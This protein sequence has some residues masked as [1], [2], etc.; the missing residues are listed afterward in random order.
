MAPSR[1]R[2]RA[3]V[4][5]GFIATGVASVATELFLEWFLHGSIFRYS[6][7]LIPIG[8]ILLGT[9]G[10]SGGIRLARVLH[11]RLG[12]FD[13]IA[14]LGIAAGTVAGIYLMA[15]FSATTARGVHLSSLM[16][17]RDFLPLAL[18][19]TH[20]ST[21][22]Q[23]TGAAGLWGYPLFAL[24]VIG[25]FAAYVG[26]Y[27]FLR[28]IPNCEQCKRYLDVI[29]K[30]QI[31][32]VPIAAA[33]DLLLLAR[34]AQWTNYAVVINSWRGVELPRKA[35]RARILIKLRQCAGCLREHL[36]EQVQIGDGEKWQMASKAARNV[37]LPRGISIRAAV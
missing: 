9:V 30:R 1:I 12:V 36:S 25:C 34:K 22:G 18:T 20:I 4:Y 6:I 19:Q 31:G 26:C 14:M 29:G 11:V 35:A 23:D 10:A 33:N 28:S 2:A 7:N 15:Y 13:L 5:A 17:F 37:Y 3:L 27:Y 21:N 16:H 24:Q 32:P 8:A